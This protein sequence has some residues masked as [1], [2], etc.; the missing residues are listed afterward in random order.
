MHKDK[1]NQGGMGRDIIK[2]ISKHK[3]IILLILTIVT[4]LIFYSN[5]SN[6]KNKYNSEVDADKQAFLNEL[7]GQKS[8]SKSA[9]AGEAKFSSEAVPTSAAETKEN[10]YATNGSVDTAVPIAQELKV[11]HDNEYYTIEILNSEITEEEIIVNIKYTV[12]DISNAEYGNDMIFLSSAQTKLATANGMLPLAEI[13]GVGL[14]NFEKFMLDN[15]D[16]TFNDVLSVLSNIPADKRVPPTFP[17]EGKLIFKKPV[18]FE[19]NKGAKLMFLSM[20]LSACEGIANLWG[21]YEYNEFEKEIFTRPF[22]FRY[23]DDI[24]EDTLDI[25]F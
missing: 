10:D 18:G 3:I 25:E 4:G 7:T 8:D 20:P 12:K 19:S 9:N 5:Y 23:E 24:F 21:Y 17:M 11:E 14:I 13:H 15:R 22:N 16:I 1:Q 6:I 2:L